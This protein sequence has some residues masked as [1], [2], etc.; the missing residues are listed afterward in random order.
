VKVGEDDFLM[1]IYLIIS[2][3]VL[4]HQFVVGLTQQKSVSTPSAKPFIVKLQQFPL[5][6][7]GPS[8][9]MM[10]RLIVK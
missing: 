7:C 3:N 1:L 6:T 10:T 2:T 4:W 5:D 8:V 9:M